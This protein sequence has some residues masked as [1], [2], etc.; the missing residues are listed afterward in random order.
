MDLQ[1]LNDTTCMRYDSGVTSPTF[2]YLYPIESII[3]GAVRDT[4]MSLALHPRLC[5]LPCQARL[6]ITFLDAFMHLLPSSNLASASFRTTVP[7]FE[8][9]MQAES[10]LC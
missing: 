2:E 8:I 4:K 9:C 7:V 5:I 10:Q 1:E 3:V 6:S